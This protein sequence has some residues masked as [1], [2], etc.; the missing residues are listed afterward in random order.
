MKKIA[1]I[2]NDWESNMLKKDGY[3]YKGSVVKTMWYVITELV[4][5]KYWEGFG[6]ATDPLN[7]V[8]LNLLGI[9]NKWTR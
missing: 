4:E 5:E 3:F 7:D 2:L 9:H 8:S 6:I 1:F